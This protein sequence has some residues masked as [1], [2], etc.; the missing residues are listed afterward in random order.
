MKAPKFPRFATTLKN[1]EGVD[2]G[3]LTTPLDIE[4]GAALKAFHRV[5]TALGVLVIALLIVG[6]V[7]PLRVTSNVVGQVIPEGSI[8]PV[9]HLEGGIIAAIEA[10]AGTVVEKGATLV[11]LSPVSAESESDQLASKKAFLSAQR[12]RYEALLSNTPP[13]YASIAKSYPQFAIEESQTYEQER[14]AFDR[15]TEG[16]RARLAQRIAT[17]DAV[18]KELAAA[19]RS[20]ALL[21]E[22]SRMSKEL[23]K[24]GFTARQDDLQIENAAINAGI[25]VT[26]LEGERVAAREAALESQHALDQL[27]AEK[28]AEWH[29]KISEIE[30]QIFELTALSLRSADRVE[31]LEIRAPQRSIVQEL[32]PKAPGEVIRPGDVVATLLPLGE[33]IIA[34]IKMRPEDAGHVKV[35]QKARVQITSFDPGLYGQISGEV[36]YIS[37]TTFTDEKGGTF[38]K[39]TISLGDHQLRRGKKRYEILPGMMVQ[40][41]IVTDQRSVLSY[42]LKPVNRAF[43]NAMTER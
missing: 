38:F 41:N 31:R 3:S 22:Q 32:R 11:R 4:D 28:K 1:W 12:L 5:T 36:L 20:R 21:E 17:R 40:A 33:S 42:L 37:P 23:L 34:E 26:R 15:S 19:R 29:A 10:K 25:E 6:A 30:A 14:A 9:N 27:Y 35:G 39:A 43:Q 18:A 24:Q 8:L 7:A 13:D 2:I 16:L